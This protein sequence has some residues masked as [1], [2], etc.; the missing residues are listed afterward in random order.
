M[1]WRAVGGTTLTL[2]GPKGQARGRFGLHWVWT[3]ARHHKHLQS[4][5]LRTRVFH[6][7]G[8]SR[9]KRSG[10][11]RETNNRETV[12]NRIKT[13][14]KSRKGSK[15]KTKKTPN[16]GLIAILF[17]HKGCTIHDQSGSR[18]DL[19]ASSKLHY[20]LRIAI[21]RRYIRSNEARPFKR[22]DLRVVRV[23]MTVRIEH[24]RRKKDLVESGR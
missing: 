15:T 7:R 10:R 16:A 20:K 3:V 21:L 23:P 18:I 11:M 14:Q 4:C 9:N 6:L 22:V 24:E 13:K 17:G 1:E 2:A 12:G 5:N 8:L 19:S